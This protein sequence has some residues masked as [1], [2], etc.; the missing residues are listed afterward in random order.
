MTFKLD[1][2]DFPKSTDIYTCIICK[3]QK[4]F[5]EFLVD[6]AYPICY[7]CNRKD[8]IEREK[9]EWEKDE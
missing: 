8:R 6:C 2:S 1:Q 7:D 4:T 5:M 3:Q 9:S